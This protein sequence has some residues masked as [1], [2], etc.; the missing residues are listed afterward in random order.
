M[1]SRRPDRLRIERLEF[2]RLLAA[3][4]PESKWNDQPTAPPIE[5]PASQ[6]ANPILGPHRQ[7]V[8]LDSGDAGRTVA[9]LTTGY[10]TVISNGPAANRVDIV[11][12][13]DGYTQSQI[14]T[15]YVDHVNGMLDYLFNMGQD[16]YPSL[17]KIL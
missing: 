12:L 8:Q 11:I 10:D 6:I 2:R 1:P 14:N 15:D 16:P 13:G 17:C 5:S 4:A 9:E 7:L 3:N